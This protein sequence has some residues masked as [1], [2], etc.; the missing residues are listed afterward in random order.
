LGDFKPWGGHR[1]WVAPEAKPRSYAPDNSPLTVA[2]VTD[3]AI[4]LTAPVEVAT[5]VEKEMHVALD[6][7]GSDLVVRH[8]ITNR[9]LWAIEAA[10][11]G[12]TIMRGGGAAIFPQEPYRSWDDYLLP[13]R[14]VVLWH[15]T[16]LTD[17]RWSI[18]KKFIRLR[19]DAAMSHPQKIG[20]M[21]KQGWAAYAREGML[22]VKRFAYE[23][24]ASYPDYGCNCETYTAGEFIEVES[25]SAF[26]R[27]EP[28]ES[29]EHV[30]R[31]SL[32]RGVET[33]ATEESLEAALVPLLAETIIS[34]RITKTK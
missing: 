19:T 10:L 28:G 24:G 4:R 23:E 14:P 1:L 9:N 20:L 27:L 6:A 31:W 3:R 12:L 26:R 34:E 17:A 5:G 33:G 29:A 7:Q 18:G 32:F 2:V 8:K 13:A 30:E 25:L 21:N 11:W 15:Y 22:F 16:D